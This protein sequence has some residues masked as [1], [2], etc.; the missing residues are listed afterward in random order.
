MGLPFASAYNADDGLP[1]VRC[2]ELK[3]KL[4]PPLAFVKA[5]VEYCGWLNTLKKSSWNCIFKRSVIL[6]FFRNERSTSLLPG[7]VQMPTPASPF[8]PIFTP[9]MVK[10]LGFSH[11]RPSLLLDWQDWPGTRF[12][13]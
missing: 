12:G 7:P 5:A 11:C 13:R 9:F 4:I 3:E 10:A 1:T 2:G 8:C 6:K